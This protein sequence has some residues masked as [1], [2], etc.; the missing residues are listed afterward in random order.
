MYMMQRAIKLVTPEFAGELLK[1]V[2]NNNQT[3]RLKIERYKSIMQS[4]KWKEKVGTP[5]VLIGGKVC[6]GRH[7][8]TAIVET[9]MSFNLPFEIHD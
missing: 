4:G 5:I 1:N 9:G 6:D 8:L 2:N 7:R 3:K